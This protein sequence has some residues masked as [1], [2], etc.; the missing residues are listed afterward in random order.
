[1]LD[2]VRGIVNAAERFAQTTKTAARST[3]RTTATASV[4]PLVPRSSNLG[5]AKSFTD[6]DKDRFRIEAFDYIA[7]YFENS[8]NELAKRNDGVDGDFRLIDTNRFTA[9]VYRVDK[10]VSRCIIFMGRGF[11]SGRIMWTARPYRPARRTS[12]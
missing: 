8:L 2:V 11:S 1:M 5:L 4:S 12:A 9:A 3:D 6:L 7:K 10:A